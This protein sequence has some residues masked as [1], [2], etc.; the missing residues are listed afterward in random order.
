MKV[1]SKPHSCVYLA[2]GM[3]A[4]ESLD[5]AEKRKDDGEKGWRSKNFSSPSVTILSC[6]TNRPRIFNSRKGWV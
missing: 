6:D 2:K 4:K 3:H 5:L 1:S